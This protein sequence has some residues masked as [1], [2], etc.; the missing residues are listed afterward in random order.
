MS[1]RRAFS[2]AIVS[3][4]LLVVLT[5]CGRS[6]PPVAPERVAPLPPANVSASVVERGV[7]VSWELPTRRAD[8]ARLRDLATLRLLR[9]DDDGSGEPKPAIRDGRRVPGY[10]EIAAVRPGEAGGEIVD[11][12]MT[13]VDRATLSAGRR[14]VYVVLAED[15]RG[16][17]S[18]PSERA[19]ALFFAA[20]TAP[21][22]PQ[23][24]PGDREIRLAWTPTKT[25][26]D[27]TAAARALAYE[28]LR[29]PGA[30][31]PFE[32]ITVTG[33]GATSFVD[34]GLENERA[35]VYAVRALRTWRGTL[36]RSNMS[37][38]VTAMPVDM[39]PPKPPTELVAIPSEGAV[40]LVWM[41][42]PDGDVGR[43]IVYRAREGGPLERAGSVPSPGTAFVD[44]DL[45]AGRWRYA[46]SAQDN[47]SRANESPRSA[48]VTVTVP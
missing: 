15:A 33:P 41:A 34:R 5:A 25:L 6:G 29:A 43:Y 42:S 2:R 27:G 19:T 47:S 38:T 11:G 17:V 37:A 44:R 14:Y 28:I 12:R 16:H 32:I 4:A 22:A 3:S 1:S 31:A 8:N 48:E 20:P 35:Y 46:V 23:A 45:A 30:D 9:A 36:A 24:T 39:T 10:T 40:R 7:E 21:G 26:S 18:P 13:Y